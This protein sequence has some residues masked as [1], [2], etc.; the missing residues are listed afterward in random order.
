MAQLVLAAAGAVIGSFAGPFGAQIGWAVGSFLGSSL[1]RKKSV[2][3][4][5]VLTDLRVT[6]TEYGQVIPWVQGHPRIAGQIWWASDRR[7]IAH[8]T[9]TGGKGPDEITVVTYTYEVDLMIGLTCNEI[10]GIARIWDNGKLIYNAL[11]TASDATVTA[12]EESEKWSRFTVYTG[13]VDQLPDPT[14][15]AA[16]GAANAP[17][18]I[19]RSY[20]FFQSYQLG[21]S[22]VIPNLTFEVVTKGTVI[23]LDF[24]AVSPS[25]SATGSPD[26]GTWVETGTISPA[27][28]N[29]RVLDYGNGYFIAGGGGTFGSGNRRIFRSTDRLTWTQV[30]TDNGVG[31]INGGVYSPTLGRWLIA[32]QQNTGMMYSDDD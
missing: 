5:S 9:A 29:V 13:A 6:G 7:P 19:G 18:Y 8:Y 2:Q 28:D 26:G 23:A 32:G 25:A 24:G 15:E 10:V 3:E 21:V 30:F 31:S 11:S 1:T 14:Y 22:G 12:S 16:V 20:A 17:A 4:G 27:M